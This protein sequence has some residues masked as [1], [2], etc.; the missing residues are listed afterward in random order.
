M[1][2]E[3]L[4]RLAIE[5]GIENDPR[6]KEDIEKNLTY[7]KQKYEKLSALEKEEFDKELLFNPYADT[8]ILNSVDPKK[9]I[10]SVLCGIDI[11]TPELLLADRL[12]QKNKEIDLVIAHHPEGKAHAKFY[13]VM[14]I[15]VDVFGRYGTSISVIEDMLE[16]RK[17]EV[18]RR[19]MPINHFRAVDAAKLLGINFMCIH[20]PAD[21]CVTKYLQQKFDQE[22]PLRVEN[23]VDI[24]KQ[25]PEYKE[26][27]RKQTGVEI[28]VGSGQRKAGKIL[29][30]MTGGTEGAPEFFEKISNSNIGTIVGMHLSEKHIE[31]A[32]EQHLNVVIAGH[33][34]S[35]TLGLNLLFDEIEKRA[36][37]LEIINCSGFYRISHKE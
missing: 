10:K 19:V 29:V 16:Q 8:R 35:D 18:A 11:E 17:Q 33:I 21:N 32:K 1:N 9:E 14:D 22:K 37:K 36:E 6:K 31:K 34:S 24:L 28:I 20:T 30:D 23:V 13:E 25:I 5:I 26:A 4:Y 2:I 12:S 7:Q 15:Q 27:A 3:Q